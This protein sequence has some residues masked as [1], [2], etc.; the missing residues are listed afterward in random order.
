MQLVVVQLACSCHSSMV[1]NWHHNCWSSISF[2][3]SFLYI[4]SNIQLHNSKY[5]LAFPQKWLSKPYQHL[6]EIHDC[7]DIL[8]MICLPHI[9]VKDTA[10]EQLQPYQPRNSPSRIKFIKRSLMTFRFR[11]KEKTTVPPGWYHNM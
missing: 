1:D 9:I 5:S 7:R 4:D 6:A 3:T 8:C 2:T 10:Q 11:N